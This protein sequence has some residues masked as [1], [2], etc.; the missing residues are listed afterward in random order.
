MLDME[1]GGIGEKFVQNAASEHAK[2]IETHASVCGHTCFDNGRSL[3]L[4]RPFVVGPLA[5][6]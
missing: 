2:L 5:R 4:A 1:V 6:N 3:T